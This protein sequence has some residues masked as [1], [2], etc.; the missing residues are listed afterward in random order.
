M[1][2]ALSKHQ[3]SLYSNL[4]VE[5]VIH[6][7]N[8]PTWQWPSISEVAYPE[9]NSGHLI[10]LTASISVNC[11]YVFISLELEA[12][13]PSCVC[14]VLAPIYNALLSVPVS[15][16]CSD[17]CNSWPKAT[18]GRKGFISSYRLIHCWGKSEQENK[19]E[20]KAETIEECCLLAWL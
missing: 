9:Q 17:K 6:S 20:R 12:W 5:L 18:Q 10:P 4:S 16:C 15:F 7:Y 1:S 2:L 19:Q 3:L 8:L 11:V 13:R 14:L